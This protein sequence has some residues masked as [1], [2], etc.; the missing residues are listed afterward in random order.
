ML[1]TAMLLSLT[2][3]S[4][5]RRLQ[6]HS[7]NVVWNSLE[8]DAALKDLLALSASSMGSWEVSGAAGRLTH[9]DFRDTRLSKVP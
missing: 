8:T 2:Q 6:S 7:R 3:R 5:H 4:S 9:R 1:F